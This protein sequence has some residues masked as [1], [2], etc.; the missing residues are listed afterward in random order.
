MI[1]LSVR[2]STRLGD[3]NQSL[4]KEGFQAITT[5]RV[6]LGFSRVPRRIPEKLVPMADVNRQA[7]LHYARFWSKSSHEA[8]ET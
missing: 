5:L 2:L 8:G 1:S 4:L 3:S 7:P 6:S